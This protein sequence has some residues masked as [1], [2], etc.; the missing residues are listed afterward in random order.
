M[1]N[2]SMS[3]FIH[4]DTATRYKINNMPDIRSLDNLLKLIYF[5][6]QPLRDK[7]KKPFIVTSGYRSPQLN[8]AIGGST[9]SHHCIGCA[10][11]FHIAGMSIAQGIEF[12]RKS[13]IKFTQLIDEGSWIH[14]SYLESNLKCEVLKYRNGVYSKI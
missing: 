10:M 3:E 9:S 4:S 13:D 14:I 5:C 1:L 12:I 11:D 8:K 7:A 6:A 2:F